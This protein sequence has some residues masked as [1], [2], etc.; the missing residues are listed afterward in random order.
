MDKLYERI[1]FENGTTPALNDTN[2]NAM[3][4]AIDDIDDRIIEVSDDVMVVVPEIQELLEDAEDLVEA[5]QT[6]A[7]NASTSEQNAQTYAQA[8]A[9]GSG[10]NALEYASNILKLKRDNTVLSE[11]TIAGGGGGGGVSDY[12]QLTN[13]PSINNVTLTGNK[14]AE[15]LGLADAANVYGSDAYNTS[16]SYA[17]GDCCIHNNK[18][19]TCLIATQGVEPPNATYWEVVTLANFQRGVNTI[20]DA[21]VSRGLTPANNTPAAFDEKIRQLNKM[22]VCYANYWQTATTATLTGCTI[23]LHNGNFTVSG[24]YIKWTGPPAHFR[25]FGVLTSARNTSGSNLISR[26]N[27]QVNNVS[28]WNTTASGIAQVGQWATGCDSGAFPFVM[29]TNTDIGVYLNMN[30][31]NGKAGFHLIIQAYID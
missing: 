1:D 13:K 22:Y 6:S 15:D 3:S 27:V 12:T 7:D 11:V 21:I 18:L 17:A 10:G 30:S 26:A 8:A 14:T 9:A 5:C 19:Y 4:K 2:L 16:T 31:A 24:N 23:F 20:Y 28:K 25:F 29:D